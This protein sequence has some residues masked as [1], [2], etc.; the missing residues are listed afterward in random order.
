MKCTMHYVIRRS[1]PDNKTDAQ[2]ASVFGGLNIVGSRA[3]HAVI[4]GGSG[5]KVSGSCSAILGGVNNCDNG[6][7]F[8]GI[9]GNGIVAAP[10]TG[11]FVGQSAFWA[12][13]MVVPNIPFLPT[14]A[15]YGSL[16]L[17][18]L[19]TT[20]LPG[21]GWGMSPVYVA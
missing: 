6:H 13:A 17:G 7:P 1:G 19:Y 20:V 11:S 18:T 16:P 10:F 5:N 15:G 8:T 2:Y 14:S 3:T 9:F 12:N 4:G 21:T